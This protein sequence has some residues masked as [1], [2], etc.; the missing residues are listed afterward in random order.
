MSEE[1]P[2]NDPLEGADGEFE[3]ALSGLALVAAA[4]APEKIAF[5]A[6]R[7]VER[8]SV[9]VWRGVSTALAAGLALAI[10]IRPAPRIER[11]VQIAPAPQLVNFA[12]AMES[13]A[14]PLPTSNYL[15]QRDLVLNGGID[16]I[17]PA[18]TPVSRMPTPQAM[19]VRPSERHLPS[20]FGG[21]L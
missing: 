3:R 16:V 13:P 4:H 15:S 19:D 21:T 17:Q 1:N 20:L 2:L 10:F 11:I 5:E 6:G 7:R 14:V 12:S 9:V 18:G 8:Q